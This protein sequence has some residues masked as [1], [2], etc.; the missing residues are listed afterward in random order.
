MNF[1]DKVTRAKA[2]QGGSG[3][4]VPAD[5]SILDTQ[6]IS[7]GIKASVA[8][9]TASLTDIPS[10]T[11]A[12]ANNTV[13]KMYTGVATKIICFGDS[14]TW[15]QQPTIG[16]QTPN[17]YPSVLQAKLRKIYNNNN[18]SVVNAGNPGFTAG[19][20][21]PVISAQVLT[22]SPDLVVFM[23]GINDAN[24]TSAVDRATYKANMINI[25]KQIVATGAELL[26]LSSTP[27]WQSTSDRLHGLLTYT[28]IV[29]DLVRQY[30]IGFIDLNK[31]FEKMY[32]FK[33][34]TPYVAHGGSNIDYVHLADTTY[35]CIA[36]IVIG[37]ALNYNGVQNILPVINSETHVIA[38]N[39]N[40]IFTDCNSIS[41]NPGQYSG[42]NY[43]LASDSSFGTYL[44]FTFFADR[45][46]MDLYLLGCK[47]KAGGQVSVLDN[48]VAVKTVDGFTNM[49][50]NTAR[51]DAEDLLLENIGYGLHTIEILVSNLIMGQSL[52]TVGKIYISEF[53]F[54]PT[55]KSPV[56][57]GYHISGT[58]NPVMEKFNKV[59]N[60]NGLIRL[61]GTGVT[62]G[63]VMFQDDKAIGLKTGKTLVIEAEGIFPTDGGITYFGAKGEPAYALSAF[64]YLIR[65]S[66]T[67]INM[68]IF[69]DTT[70][71]TALATFA[72]SPN[73]TISHK[74]RITHTTAGVIT[75]FLDNV[76]AFQLTN[77]KEK[78]GKFGLYVGGSGGN[79][80]LN[81]YEYCY[82]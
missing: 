36:E 46:G 40:C 7:T 27:I 5:N 82:R 45:D 21:L 17:P 30:N 31:E 62:W 4:G 9:N 23:C 24:P 13:T 22:Q 25:I 66:A 26:I 75:V 73:F 44:R 81:R 48:S 35:G 12:K 71:G 67:A 39:N 41:T 52:S 54:R 34:D 15:G 79:I 64:G 38:V 28:R 32:L 78:S 47:T 69:E 56:D 77:I 76:Q 70:I 3:S 50:S 20:L 6:L 65:L 72:V 80:E 43:A 57:I 74:L 55:M 60:T 19:Q 18:I 16:G 58:V 63:G 11:I 68:Y 59:C 29:E 14:I 10:K 49:I 8:S 53:V 61:D 42:Q 1:Q 37:K 51:Y 33:R 2:M